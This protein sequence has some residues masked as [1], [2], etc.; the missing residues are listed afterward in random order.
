MT[1]LPSDPDAVAALLLEAALAGARAVAAAD[2][3]ATVTK[4]DGTP[5]TVADL[6]SDAAIRALLAT[7][8]PDMPIVSEEHW[9]DLPA[10]FAERPFLL[11]D[12]LD[13]TREHLD[14]HP[15]HAVCLALI[16]GRRPVAAAI[17][18]PALAMAWTAGSDARAWRLGPDLSPADAGRPIHAAAER[19]AARVLVTS[20]SR[21]DHGL[22]AAMP[23]LADSV[24]QPRGGVLK[25]VALA[26]GAA[27]LFPARNPSSE[28]D[29]AA[30][31]ALLRAAGGEM[32]GLDGKPLSYGHRERG[33]L[34]QP[35]VAGA[36]AKLVRAA[37][38]QW[39]AN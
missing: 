24:V 22:A 33:F 20:R 7:A 18:A 8:W 30:G 35:Y 31:E 36:T 3:R 16:A 9:T 17:A 37:L 23:R 32:L 29:I 38:A 27:C 26:E 12:P 5:Q 15:D 28:W 13:G 19:T 10:D 14:G 39:P 1:V 6:A 11:V 21:P 34:N 2:R 25:L 4:A